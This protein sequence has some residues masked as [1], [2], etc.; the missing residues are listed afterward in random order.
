M[1]HI[2]EISGSEAIA[3]A[4]ALRFL[5]DASF[6]LVHLTCNLNKPEESGRMVKIERCRLRPALREDTFETD[7]DHYLPYEDIETE[8]PGMCFK[9]LM[10]YIAFPP[11]Y[12]LLKINWFLP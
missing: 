2:N 5:P 12:E 8:K 6:T 1:T 11:N 9:K 7:G 10:R 3:R 4:R